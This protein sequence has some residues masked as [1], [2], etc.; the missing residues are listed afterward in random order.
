MSASSNA[1]RRWS[2]SAI[3]AAEQAATQQLGNPCSLVSCPNHTGLTCTWTNYGRWIGRTC[4]CCPDSQIASTGACCPP[5]QVAVGAQCVYHTPQMRQP[6]PAGQIYAAAHGRARRID[7]RRDDAMLPDDERDVR[8]SLLSRRGGPDQPRR[9]ST[10][11]KAGG[12]QAKAELRDG[13]S[14]DA[15]RVVLPGK[16]G[17]RGRKSVRNAVSGRRDLPRRELSAPRSG[18]SGRP[19][20]SESGV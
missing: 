3:S 16:P 5:G 13:L 18:H 2:W 14:P 15:R 19:S 17:Q 1:R 20:R 8:R 10:N 9:L 4:V 6:C 11:S 7:Q 12:A